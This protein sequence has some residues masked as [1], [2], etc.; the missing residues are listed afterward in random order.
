MSIQVYILSKLME[1]NTYPYQLKKD[2]SEPLPLAQF[3]HLSESKLYYHFEAL[4]NQGLIEVVELVKEDNRP[5]KQM[6]A[7]TDKGREQLPKKIYTMFEKAT[8]ISDMLTGIA[9]IH[10]VNREKVISILEY[11]LATLIKMHDDIQDIS[12]TYDIVEEHKLISFFSRYHETKR[13]HEIDGL[14][15]LIHHLKT[16]AF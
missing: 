11:K 10:L 13:Q 8:T 9:F 2:L 5:D 16:K 7:I 12:S 6:F 15:E 1:K 14:T 4:T 3:I